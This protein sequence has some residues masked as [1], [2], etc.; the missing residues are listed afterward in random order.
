MADKLNHGL[1]A[2]YTNAKCRCDDCKDAAAKYMRDY[3]K[4]SI[5]KSQARF[6]QIVANK[7]SQIA[8]KWIKR[9]HPEEWDKICARALN[10][11]KRQEREQ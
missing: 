10:I 3:R 4:T 8:I 1:Y 6:H 9:N 7:R 5:G 2:T 11:V